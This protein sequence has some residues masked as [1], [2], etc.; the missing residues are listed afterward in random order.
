MVSDTCV[1]VFKD[2]ARSIEGIKIAQKDD[3]VLVKEPFVK[4]I[5]S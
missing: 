3:G 1:D 2:F 4:A 5:T